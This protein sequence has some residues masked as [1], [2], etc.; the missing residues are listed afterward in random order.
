MKKEPQ[1]LKDT[2]EKVADLL[3]GQLKEKN[4]NFSFDIPEDADKIFSDRSQIER[5]FINLIGNAIKFSPPKGKITVKTQKV[6]K[7]AQ[8]DI[9]DT[10]CGIPQDALEAIFEEFYRVD[11]P[12]NQE[13]KGTGLGLSLVKHII[14]AHNGKIWVKSKLGAGS[15]FSFTLPMVQ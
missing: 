4:I 5:V 3:S 13:A 15:T 7:M 14:E 8:V 2:I 12:I 6:D 9:S 1:A 10:G 11:N